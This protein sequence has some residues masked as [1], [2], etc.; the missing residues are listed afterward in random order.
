MDRQPAHIRAH[1]GSGAGGGSGRAG[2]PATEAE[3]GGRRMSRGEAG[4]VT[5]VKE[6]GRVTGPDRVPAAAARRAGRRPRLADVAARAGV[7]SGLVSLVLRNQPGPSAQTRARV[8]EAAQELGYRANRMASLLARRHSRHLGVLMD[9][10]NTFHA[11][12]V[13]D[14]DA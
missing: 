11:E 4:R 1:G 3:G 7:S 12:L 13:T 8:L 14:L 6:G 5:D 10:R 2:K 9:V